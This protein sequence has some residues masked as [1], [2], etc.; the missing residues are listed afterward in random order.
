MTLREAL[1]NAYKVAA[2][3]ADSPEE[4]EEVRAVFKT[5]FVS[6]KE[7]SKKGVRL[8][9]I[10]PLG[11]FTKLSKGRDVELFDPLISKKA[12][13]GDRLCDQ[14]DD[15]EMRDFAR[16]VCG[17]D[18]YDKCVDEIYQ[19][20]VARKEGE[21]DDPEFNRAIVRTL[22][23]YGIVP[24]GDYAI[25]LKMRSPCMVEEILEMC[26]YDPECLDKFQ[27]LAEAI[28]DPFAFQKELKKIQELLP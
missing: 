24:K 23:H 20:A 15:G 18:G 10:D 12:E 19:Y 6:A 3:I 5:L 26:S 11:I 25:M 2:N 1:D 28:D 21:S 16:T 17:E 27:K 8:P 4:Q 13:K 9:V 22:K 7:S 14:L